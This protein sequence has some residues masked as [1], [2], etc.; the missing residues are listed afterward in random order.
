MICMKNLSFGYKPKKP[1]YQNLNLSLEKGRI[2]GLLGKNG[3]GKSTLMR[4]ICGLLFPQEGSISVN[5]FEPKRREPAFLETLYF[6][7]E[8]VYLPQLTKT[9]YVQCYAPFYPRFDAAAFAHYLD[10]FEIKDNPKLPLLSFGQQKKFVIAFALACNTDILLLDEPTNGL[11]IPSKSQFRKLIAAALTDE[12][13][14]LISTHQIRD[15]DNL[16]DDVIILDDGQI[17][18]NT[19]IV[20]IGEK[21]CF[22]Q[23]SSLPDTEKILYSESQMLTYAVIMPHTEGGDK[24]VSLELFFNAMTADAAKILSYLTN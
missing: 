22:K 23:V 2:Y 18:V 21:L 11:D 5:S 16:I 15:L 4:S 19:S 13:T 17:V 12:K 8:Q 24:K 7:P 9:Q 1:L 10:V 6:I 14:I 20:H 3:A